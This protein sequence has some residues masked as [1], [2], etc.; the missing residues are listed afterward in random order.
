MLLGQVQQ[1][2]LYMQWP[3]NQNCQNFGA[4]FSLFYYLSSSSICHVTISTRNRIKPFQEAARKR[5]KEMKDEMLKQNLGNKIWG[6]IL[7]RTS[8]WLFLEVNFHWKPGD[9]WKVWVFFSNFFLG[10]CVKK[11]MSWT[12]LYLQRLAFDWDPTGI[13]RICFDSWYI[14]WCS[15]S[16]QCF[17]FGQISPCHTFNT[18]VGLPCKRC[19]HLMTWLIPPEATTHQC[20][21]K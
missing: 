8:Q 4:L 18:P 9:F 7:I 16:N 6:S 3:D 2:Y 11:H 20:A 19:V 5:K 12:N 15:W 13:W 17:S 1:W 14:S 10:F 21:A